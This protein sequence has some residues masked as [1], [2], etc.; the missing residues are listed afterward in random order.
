M[1]DLTLI[2]CSYNTPEITLT[3]LR[4]FMFTHKRTQRIVLIDNSTDEKTS[5]LL[6]ENKIPFTRIIGGTHGDGVNKA[7]ELCETK[8]AL[9]VD[10]DVIFLKDHSNIFKQFKDMN[11]ALM[12]KIEGDRGG[13]KIYK[14]VNPWHCFIDVEQIKLN[15][16][17]FFNETK[18]KE[19]FK[20]D[21]IYDIGSTFFEDVKNAKL[22]IGDADFQGEYYLHLEGMSWYSNKFDPSKEDTGIDFGGTHNNPGFVVLH[23]QRYGYFKQFN[24]QFANINIK[25]TFIAAEPRLLIKFPTRG[26]VEK[27]FTTLDKYYDFLSGENNVRFLITCDSGDGTMNVQSVI[28]RLKKYNNLKF[29]FG[30]SKTKIE[31]INADVSSQEFDIVLLAS[32]DMIPIV[33]GYDEIIIN[34]MCSTYP[35]FDGVLWFNDGTQGNRLNTLCILGRQYYDRFGYI[36]NP[37]YKSLWCDA[38]FTRVG[39]ILKKQT[40]FEQCIIKHEHHSLTGEGFDITYQQNEIYESVDRQTYLERQ[41]SNFK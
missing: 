37:V 1:R 5:S 34:T 6:T 17:R 4:S 18:M 22:K 38:E 15:G 25:N 21:K 8:Y 33:K 14:R 16:I 12:G 20:T 27:F 19:S 3:M 28:D 10:T 7:L 32:D 31:A 29:Q 40:Y 2:T 36:Y 13:K 23:E 26:R 39:N 9:L 35:D 30:N 11:L 24:K 41:N